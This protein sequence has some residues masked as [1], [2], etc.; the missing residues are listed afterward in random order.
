M[1]VM[2]LPHLGYLAGLA[3]AGLLLR[4]AIGWA[5][6]FE[7]GLN[8]A[9]RLLCPREQV[10]ILLGVAETDIQPGC[11]GDRQVCALGVLAHPARPAERKIRQRG[12]QTHARAVRV[13]A[14]P[15]QR[16]E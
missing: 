5:A 14:N 10:Q 3:E 4:L 15:A 16:V 11:D 9:D 1:S 8:A 13:L 12:R 6:G 7:G 2:V